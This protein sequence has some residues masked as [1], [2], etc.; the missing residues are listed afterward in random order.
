MEETPRRYN[1]Q[2]AIK[3]EHIKNLTKPHDPD[4]LTKI[5]HLSRSAVSGLFIAPSTHQVRT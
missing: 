5:Q 2:V 4:V 1:D 3:H